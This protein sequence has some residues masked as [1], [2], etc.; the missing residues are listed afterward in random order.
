MWTLLRA[1]SQESNEKAPTSIPRRW[2]RTVSDHR[3]SR[4]L[5]ITKNTGGGRSFGEGS[6]AGARDSV[7]AGAG[8]GARSPQ[9]EAAGRVPTERRWA[10]GD[11]DVCVCVCFFCC[12]FC[13]LSG[14]LQVEKVD[15]CTVCTF[16]PWKDV[17]RVS[18]RPWPVFIPR[19]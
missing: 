8:Q 7:K 17:C 10:G 13:V 14:V 4:F 5:R 2:P 19:I 9:G 3:K 11:F 12:V 6:G 16:Q 15:Y 1:R 18:L